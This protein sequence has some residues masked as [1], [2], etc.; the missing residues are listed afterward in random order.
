MLHSASQNRPGP[1]CELRRLQEFC[2][3]IILLNFPAFISDNDTDWHK[4]A[5]GSKCWLDE[6]EEE[7][8]REGEEGGEIIVDKCLALNLNSQLSS[9]CNQSVG[10]QI[11][12]HP[13]N[14]NH[15]VRAE[16]R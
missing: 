11:R 10:I 1:S 15:G 3:F 5:H 13:E 8:E 16:L 12:N 7:K 9:A 14:T 6:G 4:Q 2:Q